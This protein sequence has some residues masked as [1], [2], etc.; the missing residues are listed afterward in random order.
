MKSIL[1]L[2][3]KL[4]IITQGILLVVFQENYVISSI[5]IYKVSFTLLFYLGLT[6]NH[7]GL[8]VLVLL[9]FITYLYLN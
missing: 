9:S 6:H 1:K 5:I 4:S 7:I 8:E 2:L 3:Y